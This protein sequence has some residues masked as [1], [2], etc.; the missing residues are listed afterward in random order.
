MEYI[1]QMAKLKETILTGFDTN[2]GNTAGRLFNKQGDPNVIRKGISFLNQF[3]IYHTLLNMSFR[4]YLALIVVSYFFINLIFA[5]IYFAIGPS[6]LGI[7]DA[8][9]C[10]INAFSECFF[11]SAQ[12]L[13]TVGYGRI[14]PH[15][16]STNSVSALESLL[17]LLMF[18][19][20]TGLS[21]A[22]FAKP[23]S[24]LMFSN[25]ILV[26]PFQDTTALMFR[27]VSP[28]HHLLTDVN[29]NVTLAILEN[30]NGKMLPQFHPLHL[31]NNAAVS[32]PLNWTVVHKLTNES[33]LYNIPIAEYA[34]RKV[35][36][37]IFIKAYDENY[38]NHVQQ[39]T[40][41]IPSDI[42][43]NARF[44]Q[45]FYRNENETATILEIDKLSKYD[46]LKT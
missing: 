27:L 11:F 38:S 15:D 7:N 6:K 37:L 45:M 18:S 14:S 41:Y 35:E 20:I 25:N 10:N 16:F 17:G 8:T 5:T 34:N 44:V 12:T 40:S 29:I 32:L 13:T 31:E 46:L 30:K 21:Y 39:R 24:K 4:K 26:T 3:S 9:N 2:T 19:V 22:R 43:P 42:I 36:F 33:P 23:E 1:C 28:S